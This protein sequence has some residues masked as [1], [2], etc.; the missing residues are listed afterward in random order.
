MPEE[1]KMELFVVILNKIEVLQKILFSF[2]ELGV[3]GT[4][5]VDCRG[6]LSSLKDNDVPIFGTLR[7]ALNGTHSDE[8]KLLLT[9][10]RPEQVKSARDIVDEAVGGINNPD[11]GIIFTIRLNYTEGLAQNN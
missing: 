2:I 9:V 10:M 8:G 7:A 5:V 11:T 4:T 1:F 3:T 6:M